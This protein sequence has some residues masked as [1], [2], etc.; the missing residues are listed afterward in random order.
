MFRLILIILLFLLSLLNFFPVPAKQ[1]WYAGIAVPEFPW[2]FISFIIPL[3]I[4]SAKRT[5][6]KKLSLTLGIAALVSFTF[7]I[8]GAYIVGNNLY[9]DVNAA[10]G[11]A[12][13]GNIYLQ[14]QPF[15]FLQMITR[16]EN[17]YLSHASVFMS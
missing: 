2:V 15:G 9:K 10:F 8:I 7:P 16:S 6:Y 4:W 1:V 12:P 13:T 11:N 3:I 17:E 14:Q 5:K